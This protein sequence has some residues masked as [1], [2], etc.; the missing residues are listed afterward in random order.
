[1][2]KFKIRQAVIVEGRYDKITLHNVIEGVIIPCDGFQLYKD[3]D[4]Q[5]LIRAYGEKLGAVILTD[6]DAAGFQL[7]NRL[8]NLLNG[9]DITH[10]YIPD[11][12]GKE[13]RKA[14]PSKEGKLGVEGV[15]GEILRAAFVAAGL[16]EGCGVLREEGGV[17]RE[18]S[19]GGIKQEYL[20]KAD[21]M[22]EGLVGGENAAVKR[23][24]LQKLLNLPERLSANELQNALNRLFT[25][26]EYM[27][28]MEK[29]KK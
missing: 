28:A 15:S 12:P 21:M 11:I 10:V 24:S 17:L 20:T 4:K 6:S 22:A 29:I 9:C 18:E 27:N 13:T 26:E 7:R 2:T 16:G 25:K 8:K 14:S 1:M 5:Q 3:K 19:G 23:K